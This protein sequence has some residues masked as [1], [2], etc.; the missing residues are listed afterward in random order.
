MSI[1]VNTTIVES[2]ISINPIENPAFPQEDALPSVPAMSRTSE[3]MKELGIDMSKIS[4]DPKLLDFKQSL[5]I[6]DYLEKFRSCKTFEE[7]EKLRKIVTSEENT[8]RKLFAKK[9]ALSNVSYLKEKDLFLVPAYANEDCFVFKKEM[10]NSNAENVM[11]PLKKPRK[12]NQLMISTKAEFQRNWNIFTERLFEY[13]DWDHLFVAGGSVL[14]CVLKVPNGAD[15]DYRTLRHYYHE[16]VYSGSDLDLYIYG[17]NEDE[18]I[19]KMKDI[20]N[21]ICDAIPV[22]VFAFRTAYTITLV[23]EFP[24][25]H[26][27]IILR[28]YS[29][30]AEILMGFDVD[31]CAIGYD[32]KEVYMVPRCHQALV[33]HRN[34]IDM[35]RRSPTYEQRLTKYAKRGFD[36]EVPSLHRE[37]IDPNI[38]EKPWDQIQGLAKLII[39]E[40]LDSP[41]E[42]FSYKERSLS[43]RLNKQLKM[44]NL[45]LNPYIQS[46]LQTSNEKTSDYSMVFLPWG[47]EW[48]AVDL[49]K[50]MREKDSC[51]NGDWS[52]MFQKR[53]YHTHPCFVGTLEEVIKDQCGCCPPIPANDKSGKPI[54]KESLECF[55]HGP[56]SF[57]VDDPGRQSIGSFHPITTGEWE[58]GAYI[59]K[60]I[61]NL[62]RK[63]IEGDE[64][65]VL[66]LLKDT[67]GG[68]DGLDSLGRT[69]LHLAILGNHPTICKHLLENGANIGK[70]LVN[71]RN[72]LHLASQYGRS[73]ILNL[74]LLQNHKNKSIDE[75]NYVDINDFVPGDINMNALHFALLYGHK[76]CVELLLKEE[77]LQIEPYLAGSQQSVNTFCTLPILAL[78]SHVE[79]FNPQLACDLADLVIQKGSISLESRDKYLRNVF[80]FLSVFNYPQYTKHLLEIYDKN[81]LVNINTYD[82]RFDTPFRIAFKLQN[83]DQCILYIQNGLFKEP[84]ETEF[85]RVKQLSRSTGLL[86][87]NDDSD[88]DSDNY[89]SD[90]EEFYEDHEYKAD[91][92][93]Y[94]YKMF[95]KLLDEFSPKT[96]ETFEALIKNGVDINLLYNNETILDLY[97]GCLIEKKHDKQ[98]F[99]SHIYRKDY[100]KEIGLIKLKSKDNQKVLIH[101]KVIENI[102]SHLDINSFEYYNYKYDYNMNL[103]SLLALWCDSY[104]KEIK[105]LFYTNNPEQ[106][107]NEYK[108]I[109]EYLISLGAKVSDSLSNNEASNIFEKSILPSLLDDNNDNN[110]IY[111]D[112]DDNDND[113]NSDDNKNNNS[114]KP[115]IQ[116][117]DYVKY[118]DYK[119]SKTVEEFV[120]KNNIIGKKNTIYTKMYYCNLANEY[121]IDCIPEQYREKPVIDTI[122]KQLYIQNPTEYCYSWDSVKSFS[123]YAM[124]YNDYNNENERIRDKSTTSYYS[125]SRIDACKFQQLFQAV[126]NRDL[127]TIKSLC[128]YT[129]DNKNPLLVYCFDA[130][131]CS[132]IIYAI[133]YHYWD[134]VNLLVELAFYQY[135]PCNHNY[136]H[137]KNIKTNNFEINTLDTYKSVSLYI[138]ECIKKNNTTIN[139]YITYLE[140]VNPLYYLLNKKSIQ[141]PSF[142][143]D[144]LKRYMEDYICDKNSITLYK[145]TDEYTSLLLYQLEHHPEDTLLN[146][147]L[148]QYNKIDSINQQKCRYEI[149]NLC[150]YLYNCQ[151]SSQLEE[152]LIYIQSFSDDM[153][154]KNVRS[155]LVNENEH[156]LLERDILYDI[157]RYR[158]NMV[159]YYE[160]IPWICI[161]S[162][163][164]SWLIMCILKM[165]N[166]EYLSV[167]I[168]LAYGGLELQNISKEIQDIHNDENSKNKECT[169]VDIDIDIDI[170]SNHD[171]DNDN[172]N[173]DKEEEEDSDKEEEDEDSDKEEE[174][175]DSD[176]EDEEDSDKDSEEEEEESDKEEEGDKNSDEYEC[177]DS[178]DEELR[179]LQKFKNSNDRI[180]HRDE[181]I[182]FN[183]V[184]RLNKYTI[185]C[186]CLQMK[187]EKC[188]EYFISPRLSNDIQYLQQHGS[189][190][191]QLY[192]KDKDITQFIRY[193][194]GYPETLSLF[195]NKLYDAHYKKN[196]FNINC[197]LKE[198]DN[199]GYSKSQLYGT[200]IKNNGNR[201]DSLLY[202]TLYNGDRFTEKEYMDIYNLYEWSDEDYYLIWRR[203]PS[204]SYKPFLFCFVTLSFF[205]LVEHKN[206]EYLKKI[207]EYN[208]ESSYY[209]IQFLLNEN[210]N[211]CKYI[212]I[213]LISTNKISIILG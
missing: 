188:Y 122:D 99:D 8:Y 140:G 147:Y 112:I 125:S 175:E 76:E 48:K 19:E 73:E 128:I 51:L 77:D 181:P 169:H 195:R 30:P 198:A 108:Q 171:K 156:Y 2:S 82:F 153:F 63:V 26:I 60:T 105:T 110:D 206:T 109:V 36:I 144:Q 199:R 43:S 100:S 88:D 75:N 18:A 50:K 136:C 44:D 121:P 167:I 32:G 53:G 12:D 174:D 74:L 55:V 196:T 97:I 123:N 180:K 15:K 137:G 127:E 146:K 149:N 185:I 202:N 132:P 42:R 96:K 163:D 102:L 212:Y 93:Q 134:V 104:Y 61:K 87:V 71:G 182:D 207:F 131:G 17:L 190:A 204:D 103:R 11:F 85:N 168:R 98:H 68:I 16:D 27:Q 1:P 142:I 158:Y 155:T 9:A 78:I 148:S 41:S 210:I 89:D 3:R 170:K 172:K 179:R 191:F 116:G 101:L 34:V 59:S 24:F 31:S 92:N 84:S 133:L 157:L 165:D 23:S 72:C 120:E 192:L 154:E 107:L 6:P 14:G 160:V 64:K 29:S 10:V 135:C 67:E 145:S 129:P 47:K 54:D 57:I 203:R 186:E 118:G 124:F 152:F 79:A 25:R 177:N 183:T 22:T 150:F 81:K 4:V 159:N 37:W 58:E 83:F 176:K 111:C 213:Y 113:N 95:E 115:E 162:D 33:R 161:N 141:L 5:T 91:D 69:P 130:F 138:K 20:Y 211:T 40:K 184:V 164:V 80:H 189:R 94:Y 197:L 7:Y 35:S 65:E 205:K 46:K 166:P 86:L 187:A 194:F 117:I 139:D 126:W 106:E 208:K 56:L 13:L 173:S 38:F 66:L 151:S 52:E 49:A 143:S 178:E 200:Y 193:T 201:E 62:H 209:L 114:L 28:L 119:P 90:L 21:T 45:S 70:K 39:L